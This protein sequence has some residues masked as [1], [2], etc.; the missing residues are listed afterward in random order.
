M[1]NSR[2]DGN[3]AVWMHTTPDCPMVCQDPSDIDFLLAESK[4]DCVLGPENNCNSDY[5]LLKGENSTRPNPV[6]TQNVVGNWQV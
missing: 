2:D 4:R 1:H 3:K 6:S 5:P